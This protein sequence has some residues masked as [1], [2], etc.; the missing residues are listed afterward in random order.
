M[1]NNLANNNSYAIEMFNLAEVYQN[2]MLEASSIVVPLDAESGQDAID[3]AI[4]K[5]NKKL[6]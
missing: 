2:I 4:S 6:N 1:N 5:I 3:S